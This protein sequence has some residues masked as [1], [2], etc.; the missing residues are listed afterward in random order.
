MVARRAVIVMLGDRNKR[1]EYWQKMAKESAAT[2][3]DALSRI[4]APPGKESL[5]NELL[6]TWEA[7]R[8]TREE[9]LVPLILAGKQAEA[10]KLAKGIQA[11]RMKRTAQLC[12]AL[13]R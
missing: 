11:E 6:D 7:F 10:E 1:G 13:G 4:Y 2:V 9:V 12:D 3:S 8:K 5:F